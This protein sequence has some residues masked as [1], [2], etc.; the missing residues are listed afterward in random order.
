MACAPALLQNS[1]AA[2]Q[3]IHPL[4]EPGVLKLV[5]DYS[6]RAK[7]EEMM[8]NMKKNMKMK[9]MKKMKNINVCVEVEAFDHS[10]LTVLTRCAHMIGDSHCGVEIKAFGADGQVVIHETYSIKSVVD[11]RTLFVVISTLESSA[12]ILHTPPELGIHDK[13]MYDSIMALLALALGEIHT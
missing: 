7:S 12:H 1:N 4:V 8:K 13:S 11:E 6:K 2:E 3:M 10:S 5:A 9:N